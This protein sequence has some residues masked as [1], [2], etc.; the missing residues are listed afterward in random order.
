MAKRKL[1]EVKKINPERLMT[2]EN[3]PQRCEYDIPKEY[4]SEV[5]KRFNI[6]SFI[7]QLKTHQDKQ[8]F[9]K[10]TAIELTKELFLLEEKYR[11]RTAQVI[12]FVA[13]K[14]GIYFPHVFQRYLEYFYMGIHP[15]DRYNVVASTIRE[16]KIVYPECSIQSAFRNNNMSEKLCS[17]LCKT[18]VSQISGKIGIKIRPSIK[19]DPVSSYCEQQFLAVVEE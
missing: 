17:E 10:S 12:D 1:D 15:E 14:T 5:S 19:T 4:L 13:S 8:S 11:D 7:N 3:L 2:I 6:S 9:I 18:I 16:V